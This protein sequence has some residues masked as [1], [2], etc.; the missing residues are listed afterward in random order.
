[1]GIGSAVGKAVGK[2]MSDIFGDYALKSSEV[3]AKSTIGVDEAVPASKHIKNLKTRGVTEEEINDLGLNDLG[4]T[5]LTRDELMSE[6]DARRG[7]VS[8]QL[9]ISSKEVAPSNPKKRKIEDEEDGLYDDNIKVGTKFKTREQAESMPNVEIIDVPEQ[10]GVTSLGIN[11]IDAAGEFGE[12]TPKI[13]SSRTYKYLKYNKPEFRT[14]EGGLIPAEHGATPNQLFHL[15][16]NNGVTDDG[17][18]VTNLLEIQSDPGQP[19]ALGKAPKIKGMPF[20]NEGNWQILGMK[21]AIKQAKREGS[22]YLAIAPGEEIAFSVGNRLTTKQD[23]EVKIVQK[24]DPEGNKTGYYTFEYAKPSGREQ[25]TQDTFSE[26]SLLTSQKDTELDKIDVDAVLETLIG[27]GVTPKNVK[28]LPIKLKKAFDAYDIST[29]K[30]LKEFAWDMHKVGM[31]D[32]ID[33]LSDIASNRFSEGFNVSKQA[34]ELYYFL[35]ERQRINSEELD[36]EELL[37]M[38]VSDPDNYWGDLV[39]QLVANQAFSNQKMID[40]YDNINFDVIAD[41]VDE[42]FHPKLSKSEAAKAVGIDPKDVDKLAEGGTALVLP[43]G[44]H[45]GQGLIDFYNEKLIGKKRLKK[46]QAPLVKIKVDRPDGTYVEV[47]ALDLKDLPDDPKK[48]PYTLYTAAAA[49]VGGLAKGVMEARESAEEKSNVDLQMAEGGFVE[50]EDGS[51]EAPTG[52]L[53]EEVADDIDAKLSEGE[54]VLPADVVRYI[55]LDR[56][57]TLRQEAKEGLAKME[58]MGQMSNAN[59]ATMDDN[60]EHEPLELAEGGYVQKSG[61]PSYLGQKKPS[62]LQ[63]GSV[64]TGVKYAGAAQEDST[65]NVFDR[66]GFVQTPSVVGRKRNK[67]ED[68]VYTADT[69][70]IPFEVKRYE[71]EAGNVL[72]I[73]FSYGKPQNDIP[74]GYKEVDRFQRIMEAKPEDF[75]PESTATESTKTADTGVKT[76]AVTS[77]M[78][79]GGGD[80]GDDGPAD[81]TTAGLNWARD[82]ADTDKA[83][84]VTKQAQKD[85]LFEE[86]AFAANMAKAVFTP[87]VFSIGKAIKAYNDVEDAKMAFM[88]TTPIGQVSN[89]YATDPFSQQ[90]AMLATQNFGNPNDPNSFGLFDTPEEAEAFSAMGEGTVAGT[91]FGSM[92]EA[93]AVSE[94][95]FGSDE[96]FSAIDSDFGNLSSSADV[97]PGGYAPSTTGNAFAG[98]AS[99]DTGGTGSAGS[100]AAAAGE[101]TG[102]M[103]DTGDYSVG[104]DTSGDADGDGGSGSGGDGGSYCCTKMVEHGKWK[105]R[106]EYVQMHKWHM[107]QEQWWR[108]GYDVWGKFLANTLLKDGSEFWTSAM[109]EF[110][111]HAIEEQPHTWKSALGYGIMYLG[112]FTFGMLAKITGRHVYEVQ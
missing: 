42:K 73:P 39:E 93:E 108:D 101:A 65:Q 90:T 17:E 63:P 20:I 59:E 41:L 89:Q 77:V 46:Y 98:D 40:V 61:I 27:V 100:D 48:I 96:H 30:G 29:E 66:S 13:G 56:L 5:L 88:N 1:M 31:R 81:N 10:K 102:P 106:R 23:I 6:I 28:D 86:I 71:N 18:K 15:R 53:N 45:G 37:D 47:N 85:L 68:S 76:A 80:I 103:G 54:F 99:G 7:N 83:T 19:I 3:A 72:Y 62:Y 55:G 69:T 78:D 34:D 8:G 49:N 67:V 43:K 14:P 44:A 22:R 74:E 58:A 79:D 24:L 12:Y 36:P 64:Q 112:I 110:Y 57:M 4:D 26:Y 25:L 32:R 87:S 50:E 105:K 2:Q 95:G 52:A 84:T 70:K 104:V 97:G 111:L 16:L 33:S 92:G 38:G 9:S 11:E 94:F 91:S 51:K 109:H 82:W 60:A 107:K 75:L 21:E 35:N